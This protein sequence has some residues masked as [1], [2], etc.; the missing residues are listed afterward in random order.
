ML[1]GT[2]NE[3]AMP[4]P[5]IRPVKQKYNYFEHLCIETHI[6]NCSCLNA[7]DKH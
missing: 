4:L 3:A 2:D 7:T 6:R 5:D 1:Q